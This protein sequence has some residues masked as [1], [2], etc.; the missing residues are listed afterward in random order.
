MNF[1]MKKL[2]EKQL[3]NV[4]KEQAEMI[5]TLV[6]KNPDLFNRM[7]KEIKAK[8]KSG[9]DQQTASMS[10]MMAHKDEIQK[11]MQQR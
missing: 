11:A 6:E 1:L 10:V 8:V 5:M 4:P 9:L 3:K 2:L 7:S